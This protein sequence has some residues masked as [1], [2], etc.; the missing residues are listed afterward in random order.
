[1]AEWLKAADLK[2]ATGQP[3]E[4]SNPSFSDAVKF[5]I[6]GA[7]MSTHLQILKTIKGEAAC[8]IC[9]GHCC[10]RGETSISICD[11]LSILFPH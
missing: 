7:D 10:K 8:T 2:S 6:N 3:V 9:R 5:S 1:M 4:G 11:N